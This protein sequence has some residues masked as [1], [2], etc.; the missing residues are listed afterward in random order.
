MWP[1]L[2]VAAVT[3]AGIIGAGLAIV[4][5]PTWSADEMRVVEAVHG[6][7][8]AV[9][10]LVALTINTVFGP[11]GAVLVVAV[12]LAWALLL[13]RSWRPPLR[14]FIVLV[15]PW[16]LAEAIK[17][18]VERP[19]PDPALLSPAVIPDPATFSYPSG[20]TAFAAALVCALIVVLA[21]AG[22]R[23]GPIAAGTVIV[24]ITAWSRIYLGVH[25]PTDVAA[26]MLLVPIT[27]VAVDRVVSMWS[28]FA[29]SRDQGG[30]AAA[31][32]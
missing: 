18:V 21:P 24:L 14:I 2:S 7:H 29:A 31:T 28:W 27:A 6:A 8:N 26:S 5:S 30:A 4:A 16:V 9:F 11:A 32:D 13:T 1:I 15:V 19:R 17:P 25:Y 23:A 10:D 12:S 22:S 20:H 3:I